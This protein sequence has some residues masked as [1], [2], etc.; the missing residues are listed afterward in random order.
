[1][2]TLLV[3]DQN[4]YVGEAWVGGQGQ[5]LL[6]FNSTGSLA[7]DGVA[8]LNQVAGRQSVGSLNFEGTAGYSYVGVQSL[9]YNSTGSIVFDGTASTSFITQQLLTFNSLG[10]VV[11][12]GA[13]SIEQIQ[14]RFSTGSLRFNGAAVYRETSSRAN[15]WMKNPPKRAQTK[16]GYTSSWKDVDSVIGA[17]VGPSGSVWH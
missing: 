7:F 16:D 12:S 13:G 11:F 17:S 3:G 5:Q 2:P 10:S 14:T 6:D 9:N 8:T 4:A 1:M 15:V